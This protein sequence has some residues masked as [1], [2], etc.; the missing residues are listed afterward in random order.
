[1]EKEISIDSENLK[2]VIDGKNDE[3]S[4]TKL[5]IFSFLGLIL[6]GGLFLILNEIL[7]IGIL[8]TDVTQ[9]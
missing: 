8:L 1:M 4:K 7:I 2:I 9:V 6:L 3:L 5:I